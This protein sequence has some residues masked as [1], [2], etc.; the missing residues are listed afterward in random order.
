M[1]RFSPDGDLIATGGLD[2]TAILWN[3][4]SG[5]RERTLI[6][7]TAPI[8]DIAFDTK[9]SRVLTAGADATVRVWDVATGLLVT[10]LPRGTSSV[11]AAEFDPTN[12]L[13]ILTATDDG[14]AQVG[15]CGTCGNHVELLRMADTQAALLRL[16][17]G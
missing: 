4:K 17:G 2:K 7:H 8:W 15:V 1:V 5:T 10:I 3:A 13:R 11:N 16:A 6:G 12:S 14:V 9:G